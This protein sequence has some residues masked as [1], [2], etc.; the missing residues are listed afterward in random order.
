MRAEAAVTDMQEIAAKLSTLEAGTQKVLAELEDQTKELAGHIG[1]GDS[2]PLVQVVIRGT[3]GTLVF[4]VE[5]KGEYPLR[6]LHLRLVDA[7]VAHPW[8]A[9]GTSADLPF[10]AP[11]TFAPLTNTTFDDV[12][13][14][15]YGRLII[16]SDALNGVMY[17]FLDYKKDDGEWHFASCVIAHGRAFKHMD[18]PNFGPQ[19][20]WEGERM[21]LRRIPLEHEPSG[22]IL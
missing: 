7:S 15:D 19:P 20:D 3:D 11:R 5:C 8:L 9:P 2:Y 12:R 4:I 1:G 21:R 6:G 16:S 10:V 17:Q 18:D 22:K 13:L 14:S